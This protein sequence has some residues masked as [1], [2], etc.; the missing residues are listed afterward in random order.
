MSEGPAA[1][2]RRALYPYVF[3]ARAGVSRLPDDSFAAMAKWLAP[4][5]GWARHAAWGTELIDG[6]LAAFTCPC[7]IRLDT[8]VRRGKRCLTERRW[9]TYA[10]GPVA[11][12]RA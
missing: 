10:A 1:P 2:N 5:I 7:P 6:I 8:L 9:K 12:G 11:A 3:P 4:L